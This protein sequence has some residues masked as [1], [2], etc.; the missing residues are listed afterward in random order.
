[1]LDHS[2]SLLYRPKI[3]KRLMDGGGSSNGGNGLTKMYEPTFQ[4][5]NAQLQPTDELIA[6]MNEYV[7][8]LLSF[9]LM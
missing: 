5:M 9:E 8:H 2:V 4:D 7:L 3:L 6:A 1:M